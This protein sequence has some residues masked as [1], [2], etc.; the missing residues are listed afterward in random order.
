MSRPTSALVLS[1]ASLV[2][3]VLQATHAVPWMGSIVSIVLGFAGAWVGFLAIGDTER[4]R[5]NVLAWSGAIL[6]TI[7]VG[8]GCYFFLG[9]LLATPTPGNR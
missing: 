3:V 5:D 6:G 8:I 9:P 4:R 1:L 7:T 2:G